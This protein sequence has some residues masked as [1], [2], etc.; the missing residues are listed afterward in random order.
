MSHQKL[1]T[2]GEKEKLGAVNG[3][4][5]DRAYLNWKTWGGG[6]EVM[7][8]MNKRPGIYSDQGGPK[9]FRLLIRRGLCAIWR[10]AAVKALKKVVQIR[11]LRLRR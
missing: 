2:T 11:S 4:I 9:A 5:G 7:Q 6:R 3:I 8:T 10:W 1:I